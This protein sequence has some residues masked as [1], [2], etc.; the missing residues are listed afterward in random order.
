MN[1]LTATADSKEELLS[2]SQRRYTGMY[3]DKKGAIEGP[4]EGKSM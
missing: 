3:R 2:P 4:C 1:H